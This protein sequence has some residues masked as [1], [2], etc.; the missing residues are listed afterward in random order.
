MNISTTSDLVRE[1]CLCSKRYEGAKM[2]LEEDRKELERV[3]ASLGKRLAPDD[4]EEGEEI[5][6]WVRVDRHTERLVC[7][8]KLSDVAYSVRFRGTPREAKEHK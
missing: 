5:G 1:W 7:V 6:V 4:L 8:M 2:R 3:R